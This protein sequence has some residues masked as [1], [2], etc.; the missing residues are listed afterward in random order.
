MC[1]EILKNDNIVG[2]D[3]WDCDEYQ[4]YLELDS[5][6]WIE[7]N[8][9]KNILEKLYNKLNHTLIAESIFLFDIKKYHRYCKRI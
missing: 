7:S 3:I 5:V 2:T 1:C 6:A 9:S 8:N 4:D